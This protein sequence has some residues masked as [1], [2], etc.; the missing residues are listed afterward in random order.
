VLINRENQKFG[1]HGSSI[2]WVIPTVWGWT[3]HQAPARDIGSQFGNFLFST[4]AAVTARDCG[5]LR[6]R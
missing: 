4:A 5:E 2:G 3:Q 6:Q 1:L